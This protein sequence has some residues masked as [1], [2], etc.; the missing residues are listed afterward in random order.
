M[1]AVCTGLTA[2]AVAMVAG[3]AADNPAESVLLRAIVAMLV[4]QLIGGAVGMV[5]E[6][7]VRDAIREYKAAH[8]VNRSSTSSASATVE[9]PVTAEAST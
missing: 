7:V 2:F 6:R 9:T 5:G 1:I 4:C 8:P 3:L